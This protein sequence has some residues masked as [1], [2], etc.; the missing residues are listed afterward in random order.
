M[1]TEDLAKELEGLSN[2]E[3][4]ELLSRISKAI[5]TT[6]ADYLKGKEQSALAQ[7]YQAEMGQLDSLPVSHAAK[8]RKQIDIKAKYRRLGLKVY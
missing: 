1:N 5:D 2:D 3:K 4:S 8:I 6:K 7:K